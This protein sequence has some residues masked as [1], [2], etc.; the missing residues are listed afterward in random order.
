MRRA[1]VVSCILVAVAVAGA[2]ARG[3]VAT[4]PAARLE[5]LDGARVPAVLIKEWRKAENKNR[6]APVWFD[7]LGDAN[8]GRVRATYFSGGWGVVVDKSGLPGRGQGTG[9]CPS[10]GRAVVGMAGAGV[11]G[12]ESDTARWPLHKT[13]PSGMRAGYGLEGFTMGPDWLAYV[14]IPGQS[15]LYNV[16]SYVGRE[17]LEHLL[18][19]LRIVDLGH[20]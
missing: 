15:C 12:S 16:W 13:W 14:L 17:H 19:H 3:D 6:C 11:I 8:G 7:D 20:P 10:C 5:H 4:P 1:I 18:D 2:V 9:G